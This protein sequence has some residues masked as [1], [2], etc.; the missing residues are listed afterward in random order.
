MAQKKSSQN[1]LQIVIWV[2]K[3]VFHLSPTIIIASLFF[4][5]IATSLPFFTNYYY[6]K[7]IDALIKSSQTHLNYWANPLIIFL[8]IRTI[9][10]A[11]QII[12]RSIQRNRETIIEYKLRQMYIDKIS[13]LDH[14]HFDNKDTSNLIA[15]V[16]DEY[17]WRIRQAI[18]DILD[19]L[20]SVFSFIATITIVVSHYWYLG[21]FLLLAQL[22]SFFTDHKWSRL[23]WK[24]HHDNVENMRVGNELH[25]QLTSKRFLSELN[26]N[27]ST[28]YLFNKFSSIFENIISQRIRLRQDKLPVDIFYSLTDSLVLLVCFIAIINDIL[29]GRLTVGLFTFYFSAMRSTGDHFASLFNKFVSLSEQ[30]MYLYDFK[31]TIE[32]STIIKNGHQKINLKKP[33]LIEFRHVSFH[34]PDSKRLIFD[35][36]DLS[37]KPGEEIAIVGQNGAGKT[38]LI[39]L[40]CRFYD[41]TEGQILIN[42]VD[43]RKLDIHHYYQYLSILFQEFTI[44]PNLSLKENIIIGNPNKP[45]LEKINQALKKSE[46]IDFIAK[47]DKGLDSLMG[48]KFGGEEPSWGQW[49][50][51]A[52]A[53]IFYR[54]TPIMILDEPTASIDAISESKIFSRLYKQTR[55]KTII[56]VSHR[57]STVR[58]ASR[59]IVLD[60]GKIIEEGS[61]QQLL[62]QNGLY[63]K[64]FN[65][66]AQGYLT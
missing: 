15:K 46:A 16:N 5:T 31:K 57:F 53:R 9:S 54:N 43:F 39:K 3:L 40:L 14:Q 6:A 38:T 10:S 8:V 24:I 22:P 52:I 17:Q 33:P 29:N 50:K 35:H 34:Y 61:H 56:V 27:H 58:N 19:L 65:L 28:N 4:L 44:Y 62:D 59:I 1:T 25:S 20:G 60:Q 11:V 36:L 26:I 21:I 7:I 18:T 2:T 32:L 41:P 55:G 13:Q 48:Q 42:G 64:S 63:A 45:S 51:I 12:S 23:N 66:Q 37:I 47:Y 30:S 49:Q